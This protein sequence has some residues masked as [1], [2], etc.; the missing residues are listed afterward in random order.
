MLGGGELAREVEVNDIVSEI[1][2]L[3][4]VSGRWMEVKL[5]RRDA[6]LLEFAAM[7]G[8]EA[9]GLGIGGTLIV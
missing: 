4:G 8:D 5:G 1:F 2:S 7:P 3:A 9:S 6:C